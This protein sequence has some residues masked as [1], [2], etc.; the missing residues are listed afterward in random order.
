MTFRKSESRCN[1]HMNYCLMP[2]YFEC[3]L[4]YALERNL[5]GN[6][7]RIFGAALIRPQF[8]PFTS[9]SG[10]SKGGWEL[11]TKHH[12]YIGQLLVELKPRVKIFWILIYFL[13]NI[14]ALLCH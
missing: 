6:I 13:D 2:H 4:Y 14:M 9:T 1:Y 11:L 10:G 12:L 7:S 3:H 8:T 5:L